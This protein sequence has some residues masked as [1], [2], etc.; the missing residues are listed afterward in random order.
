[1]SDKTTATPA[2][3]QPE[4]FKRVK[5]SLG[6]VLGVDEFDQEQAYF[7]ERD[8]LQN[9]ALHGYG[10]V[11]GLD[12]GVEAVSRI[13]VKPGLAIDRLG[14]EIC[15]G[16]DQCADL[17]AWYGRSEN[18]DLIQANGESRIC[19]TLCYRECL[20]DKVPIPGAPC[21]TEEEAMA[22]SRVSESFALKLARQKPD[23]SEIADVRRFVRLLNRLEV[24]RE[25]EAVVDAGTFEEVTPASI[26][27]K[28]ENLQSEADSTKRLRISAPHKLDE[29]IQ[30]AYEAWVLRRRASLH[31]KCAEAESL[32]PKTGGA[33]CDEHADSQEDECVLL[34]ELKVTFKNSAI[35]K[36]ELEMTDRPYLLHTQLL[37]E[38]LRREDVH[39]HLAGLRNDDHPQYLLVKADEPNRR[40]LIHD[41]DAGQYRLTNL[42]DATHD[43]DAI[44]WGQLY[45][46]WTA[47]LPARSDLGGSYR[48]PQVT[49]LQGVPV[50]AA[51]PAKPGDVLTFNG[52][53]WAP[54]PDATEEQKP[55]LDLT[56]IAK[57]GPL[58]IN[59]LPSEGKKRLA[60]F[61][62]KLGGMDPIL[63]AVWIHPVPPEENAQKLDL[64]SIDQGMTVWEMVQGGAWEPI[65]GAVVLGEP[66]PNQFLVAL[67][68]PEKDDLA[69]RTLGF[70][71]DLRKLLFKD[72]SSLFEALKKAENLY[73]G[74]R[75][76]IVVDY[77]QYEYEVVPEQP[78]PEPTPAPTPTPQP[79]K[80]PTTVVAAG[81]FDAEGQPVGAQVGKIQRVVQRSVPTAPGL[82]V[83]SVNPPFDPK[84]TYLIKGMPILQEH[85]AMGVFEQVHMAN[86]TDPRFLVIRSAALHTKGAEFN[87]KEPMA[88]ATP[89]GF[90]IEISRVESLS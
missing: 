33:C 28:V 11:W 45:E 63:L 68:L 35:D 53:E 69:S 55:L 6:L 75:D 32:D 38:L 57:A 87:V 84:A 16:E 34:A 13:R 51:K 37:Q 50:S 65:P 3:T 52:T 72:G 19:V 66:T 70:R 85:Q 7:K 73:L 22:P 25:G 60:E 71:L 81:R 59:R 43:R 10:T 89:A 17:S 31:P 67:P 42:H 83:L 15:V 74:Q 48:R 56:S 46:G 44:A 41:L 24:W 18:K 14:R 62:K 9:R 88:G 29:V 40:S 23:M 20:T 5:Y 36:V 4:P 79:T 2:S 1:M 47:G 78:A 61:K 12:V 26:R 82:F 77:Y 54:Q 76:H 49:G 27:I 58:L 80:S 86:I 39:S 90:Y 64:E 8:R 21:R 30:A